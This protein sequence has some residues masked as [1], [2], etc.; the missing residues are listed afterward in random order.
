MPRSVRALAVVAL[1]FASSIGSI[2]C[3]HT[4]EFDGTIFHAGRLSF[5]AGPVSSSWER[6][7]LDGPLLTFHDRASNGSID[8]YAKCGEDRLDTSLVA[9]RTQL[10]IGF[11]ERTFREEKVVPFDR[12]EALH[13]IVDAKLDGVPVSLDLYVYKKNG[14]VYDIVYVA[15]PQSFESGVQSFEAFAAGF[16]AVG[17]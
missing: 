1:I 8:V 9:L 7:Q 6:V 3:P 13:S 4:D 17:S 16:S 11:T 12:R 5:R 2:G 15:R 14:C 10:L